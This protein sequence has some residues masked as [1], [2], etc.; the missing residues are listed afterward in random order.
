MNHLGSQTLNSR[1]QMGGLNFLLGVHLFFHFSCI[2]F[3]FILLYSF[4]C[5]CV[6]SQ[7]LVYHCQK[8]R[9]E[10]SSGAGPLLLPWME[11]RS[12]FGS[13]PFYFLSPLVNPDN[14]FKSPKIIAKAQ[15][16]YH[17]ILKERGTLV[18]G[19]LWSLEI[20]TCH[21]LITG[22]ILTV[23]AWQT[24]NSGIVGSYRTYQR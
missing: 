19:H 1:R 18:C 5:M 20:D 6:C 7:M 8:W 12:D 23:C 3:N 22:L 14:I 11:L 9:P 10:A 21:Q 17:R 16:P 15:S 24:F 2:V 4:Y 13:K